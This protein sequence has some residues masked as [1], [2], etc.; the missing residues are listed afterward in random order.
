MKRQS[1]KNIFFLG[2]LG[3][4]VFFSFQIIKKAQ[5]GAG[6]NIYGWAWSETIGWI[7][8]NNISGGGDINYGANIDPITSVISGYTWSENIG[9]I[10]FNQA[11]LFGCPGFPC[12]AWVEPGCAT[13]QCDVFGWARVCSVFQANCSG[14]L[15]PNRG[16]WEGWNDGCLAENLGLNPPA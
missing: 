7:S 5:A 6:Q 10:T 14:V 1:I 16:G 11:E 9:W 15:D 3:I 2:I 13:D 8:F 12:L 4:L